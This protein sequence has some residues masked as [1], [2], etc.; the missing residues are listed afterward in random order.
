MNVW[1]HQISGT[2][3]KDARLKEVRIRKSYL[4]LFI[5][6]ELPSLVGRINL[7]SLYH[8]QLWQILDRI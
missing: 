3:L 7:L 4:F 2:C 5:S 6:G 8:N 1:E